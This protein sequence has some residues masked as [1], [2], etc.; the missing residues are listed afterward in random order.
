MYAPSH[1]Q[2]A[3]SYGGGR[4]YDPYGGRS[5]PG[6]PGSR[7]VRPFPLRK[8]VCE[9]F[10]T[11]RG[12]VKGALCDFIHQKNQVCSFWNS[13]KGC[14]K[15]EYCDFQHPPKTDGAAAATGPVTAPPAAKDARF[16]PY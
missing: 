15:G 10:S 7:P 2:S 1:Q 8:K 16:K 4:G 14:R 9:F 11:E 5:G 6:G 13:T 3:P 12:C